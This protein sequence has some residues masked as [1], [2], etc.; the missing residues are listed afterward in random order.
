MSEVAPPLPQGEGAGGENKIREGKRHSSWPLTKPAEW[1]D[2]R[3]TAKVLSLPSVFG[4]HSTAGLSQGLPL[5]PNGAFF[6]PSP[7]ARVPLRAL[8]RSNLCLRARFAHR[9][10]CK[11]SPVYQIG[12]RALVYQFGIQE[13]LCISVYAQNARVDRDCFASARAMERARSEMAQKTRHLEKAAALDSSRRSN[14]D[15]RR[16]A[17]IKPLPSVFGLAI[18]PAWSRAKTSAAFLLGFY[19]PPPPPLPEGEGERP[20]TPAVGFSY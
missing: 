15:R 4:R 8:M 20:Q 3:R 17:E 19:S 14:G 12:I 7:S 9:Q 5:S 18:L 6:A 10:R 2:R 1:Q 16:T 11:A 13:M